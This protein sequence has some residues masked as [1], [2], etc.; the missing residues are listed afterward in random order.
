MTVVVA[1]TRAALGGYDKNRSETVSDAGEMNPWLVQPSALTR[2][3]LVDMLPQSDLLS[4]K[5]HFVAPGR[6]VLSSTSVAN[7][8]SG[9]PVW[10]AHAPILRVP[11]NG[12]Q[13]ACQAAGPHPEQTETPQVSAV[14]RSPAPGEAATVVT[15]TSPA[16]LNRLDLDL[17]FSFLRIGAH[18]PPNLRKVAFDLHDPGWTPSAYEQFGDVLCE[19]HDVLSTSKTGSCSLIPFEVLVPEDSAPITSRPHRINPR[20]WPKK[21]TRPSTS[22]SRLGWSRTRHLHIQ[23]C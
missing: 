9:D 14:T 15:S 11:L 5:E 10:V 16:L 2:Q 17:R 13:H 12:L 7:L 6:Q 21:W 8:E 20:R 4:V 18:L 19:F 1:A 3:Y 22:T 23:I